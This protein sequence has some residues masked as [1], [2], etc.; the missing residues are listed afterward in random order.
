MNLD[1]IK[2]DLD[3]TIKKGGDSKV[4]DALKKKRESLR[5]NKVN[6]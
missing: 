2:R 3:Q 6:K 4:I 1:R 5:E